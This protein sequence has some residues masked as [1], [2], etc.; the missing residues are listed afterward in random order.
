[1]TTSLTRSRELGGVRLCPFI[2]T[3]SKGPIEN[4]QGIPWEL[5]YTPSELKDLSL[6]PTFQHHHPGEQ[7]FKHNGH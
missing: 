6:D 3:E 7:A 4:Y 2:T 1:M 5:P